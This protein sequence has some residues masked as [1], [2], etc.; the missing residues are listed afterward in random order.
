[1]P[2]NSKPAPIVAWKRLPVTDPRVAMRAVMGILLVA[3]LVVA[4][5]AFK[6]FGGSADDLRQQQTALSAQLRQ[7]KTHLEQTKLTVAKIQ[8]AR[9]EGDDFLNKYIMESR[10]LGELTV[11]EMVKSGTDAGVH[12]LPE[13]YN[14]LDIEGSDTLKLVSITAGFDGNYAGLAKLLNLLEKSPRFFIIDS[15]RL[16]APQQNGPTQNAPQNLNIT[17]KLITFE[18]QEGAT[19]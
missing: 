10:S 6:P 14:Y 2:K 12:L 18:R 19:P 17:F 9:T 13:Q 3:N 11:A 1:M 5:I 16:N 4:V 15:M 8:I 7:Q